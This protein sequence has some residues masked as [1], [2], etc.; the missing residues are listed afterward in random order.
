[1]PLLLHV[2]SHTQSPPRFPLSESNVTYISQSTL[3]WSPLYGNHP[4]PP[5]AT[6]NRI[7]CILR[8]VI[9]SETD[10]VGKHSETHK[11][12]KDVILT[13]IPCIY[14]VNVSIQAHTTYT[15]IHTHASYKSR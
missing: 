4:Y 13:S 6:T 5:T 10:Y 14:P 3:F 1:M 9:K 15:H 2:T 7:K 11:L 12:D 8:L